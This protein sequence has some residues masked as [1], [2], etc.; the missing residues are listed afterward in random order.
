MRTTLLSLI[1][2]AL[3]AAGAATAGSGAA[4]GSAPRRAQLATDCER[5]PR[6]RAGEPE[7]VGEMRQAH[8]LYGIDRHL[9]P[10]RGSSQS[11]LQRRRQLGRREQRARGGH[12]LA[13][14]RPVRERPDPPDPA[15]EPGAA[16]GR[17]RGLVRLRL[18][19]HLARLRLV[20]AGRRRPSSASPETAPEASR[21][22]RRP[23]ELPLVPGDVVGL[24]RGTRTGFNMMVYAEGVRDPWHAAHHRGDA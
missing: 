23:N 1:V 2:V 18:R 15:P 17:H 19:H 12:E 4:L 16:P 24:P 9:R 22:P 11:G 5:N 14:R 10:Q 20:H 6:P 21:T 13:D 8:R 7:L 3:A